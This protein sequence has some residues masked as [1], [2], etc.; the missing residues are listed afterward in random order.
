MGVAA[1]RARQQIA[2]SAPS[3]CVPQQ[4]KCDRERRIATVAA[5]RIRSRLAS[6]HQHRNSI[7][8]RPAIRELAE[9]SPG[10]RRHR[11]LTSAV[12]KSQRD[13][14]PPN[15]AGVG[16]SR[17]T[18]AHART[19]RVG[20]ALKLNY[21]KKKEPR[22]GVSS[23]KARF[24]IGRFSEWPSTTRR[25]EL[26]TGTRRNDPGTRRPARHIRLWTRAGF[27]AFFCGVALRQE[28]EITSAARKRGCSGHRANSFYNRTF[29]R[30]RTPKC[31]KLVLEASAVRANSAIFKVRD[32]ACFCGSKYVLSM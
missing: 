27:S 1:N 24:Y 30:S 23:S 18:G 3:G 2:R 10:G 6:A 12:L 32:F 22:P 8:S 26:Q 7:T 19:R 25:P 21:Y 11:Y 5:A 28:N 15:P 31:A 9:V 17:A 13:I 29:A 20:N 14:G 16:S 4:M